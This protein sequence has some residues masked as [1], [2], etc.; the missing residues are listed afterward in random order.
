MKF[1]GGVFI[2][3]FTF[4]ILHNVIMYTGISIAR[5]TIMVQQWLS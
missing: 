1:I 5:L 3:L 2:A 4:I